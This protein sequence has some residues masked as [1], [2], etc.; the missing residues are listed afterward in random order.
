MKNIISL[1]FSVFVIFTSNAMAAE[2]PGMYGLLGVGSSPLAYPGGLQSGYGVSVGA[3]YNINQYYGIEG[4]AAGLGI[5]SASEYTFTSFSATV[6]GHIPVYEG[7]GLYVKAGD[8]Y[9]LATFSP[10]GGGQGSSTPISGSG[11]VYGAGFEFSYEGSS[12]RLGLDHYDLTA[13]GVPLSTNY[14]N[15]AGTTHF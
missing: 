9:T 11:A 7:I 1:A 13:S 8:G 3:G 12:Y 5:S 14:I 4:V 10:A 2:Q 15:V 6:V